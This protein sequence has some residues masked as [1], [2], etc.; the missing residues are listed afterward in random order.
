MYTEQFTQETGI[1]APVPPQTLTATGNV[2]SGAVDMS[3]FKRA[4]FIFELGVFGGTSPTDSCVLQVQESPDN[5][6]W[7]NNATVPTATVSTASKQA[8]VEIRADQLG[9]GKRYV[10]LQCQHTIGGTSPTIP[11]A[12]VALGV[13]AIHKPG[14]AQND[15]S[16]ISQTT[17]P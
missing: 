11:T 14:S 8:T 17:A 9:S 5:A 7:T 12:V 3:Q 2:N 6:T 4:F 15:A 16:V 10:R 1:A 13:D